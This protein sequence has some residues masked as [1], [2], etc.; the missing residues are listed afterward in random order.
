MPSIISQSLEHVDAL[1]GVLQHQMLQTSFAV[2]PELQG[3]INKRN[4]WPIKC[5][6]HAAQDYKVEMALESEKQSGLTLLPPEPTGDYD[7]HGN[8]IEDAADPY[9][10]PQSALDDA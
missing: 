4:T 8:P 9:A 10:I 5:G 2:S 6:M 7:E 1:D 3:M